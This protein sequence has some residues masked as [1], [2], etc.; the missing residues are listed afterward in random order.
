MTDISKLSDDQLKNASYVIEAA[1]AQGVDP[2]YALAVASAESGF[3]N[4]AVSK[5]GAIGL[6]QLMPAT[7][8]YLKVNPKDPKENAE[9]GVRYLKQQ[10]EAFNGDK[11]LAS[12][13][14]NAGPGVAQQFVKSKD[15][16]VIPDESLAYVNR[17][18]ALHPLQPQAPGEAQ[19]NLGDITGAPKPTEQKEY[20]FSPEQDILAGGIGAVTGAATGAAKSVGSNV[21]G[22]SRAIQDMPAALRELALKQSFPVPTDP[23]HTRQMQ[24]TTEQGATG[25]ARM[26]TFNEQTAQQAAA[27]AQQEKILADLAKRGIVSPESV[28]AKTAGVTSTPS[29]V[30]LPSG[31]VYEPAAPAP[32]PKATPLQQVGQGA[33]AIGRGVSGV[34]NVPMVRGA[35]GGA[36]V[37]AGAAETVERMRNEDV[38]GAIVSG[39]GTLGSAAAM[40]PPL[41]PLGTAT[42]LGATGALGLM[43]RVRNQPKA[44]YVEP[45]PAE[46]EQAAK[47]AFGI[48]PKQ[49]MRPR[50]SDPNAINGALL[51]SLDQQMQ[52]FQ[53]QPG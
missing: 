50:Q 31:V 22:M 37:G 38:P 15:M 26:T 13:A 46:L 10:L 34:L 18:N 36:G 52:E 39:I 42:A 17:I 9:G 27:R 20:G 4:S 47:P 1:N 49:R 35:L 6:M 43:D 7:A 53:S 41:A 30:L 48:Y 29:G 32:A 25:R 40:Y 23:Q 45:T 8:E 33:R 28:L 3:D 51:N 14:Y 21:A 19:P 11:Y 16:S 44:P 5:K 2:N 24:G 12:I